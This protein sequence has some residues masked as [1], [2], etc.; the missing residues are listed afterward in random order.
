MAIK[1]LIKADLGAFRIHEADM[2]KMLSG[3][4]GPV[5][6]DL[7]RR[8]IRVEASAKHH[9]SGR[10]G[11]MVRTGRLRGSITWRL[12][13]DPLSPYVDVGST[14]LYAPFVELGTSRAPEYPYL[15]PALVS[16][17]L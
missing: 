16:A 9:A 4:T 14:V 1:D 2:R 7:I 6:R 15:R 11:P 8:G 10:P 12:G 17:R 3:P 13:A 5:V